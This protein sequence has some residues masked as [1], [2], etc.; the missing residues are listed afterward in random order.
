MSAITVNLF[1]LS[2]FVNWTLPILAIFLF[3]AGRYLNF[4]F[5]FGTITF[6]FLTIANFFY[7]AVQP[8]QP[9]LKDFGIVAQGGIHSKVLV[10]N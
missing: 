8:E 4:Y 2:K 6:L 10:L 3:V 7:F 9:L 1:R 5:H